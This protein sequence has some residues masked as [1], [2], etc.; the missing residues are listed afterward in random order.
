MRL[1]HLLLTVISLTAIV[2]SAGAQVTTASMSGRITDSDEGSV[3]GAVVIA[4][5][6]ASGT[7]YGATT[8][9]EGRFTMQGMRVGA[10]NV[11]ITYLG[12]ETARI[13]DVVLQLGN[14]YILDA[15]LRESALEL[16]TVTVTGS[17]S[18]FVEEKT[19]P[20]TNINNRQMTLVPSINRSISDIARL[21]PY[22]NGLSFAGGDGRST[23]FTVDG[24]N[25]NNNFGLSSGL[26][27]G[28][29]P[30]SLDAIEE[31]QVVIA[32][33]DVRQ[34]NFIGG[35]INAIT[36]SGTNKFKGSAYV[37]HRDQWLRG[38]HIGDEFLGERDKDIRTVYGATLGGPIVKNRLF[39]FAN[40]EYEK[41][42]QDGLAWRARGDSEAAN[43]AAGISKT[44][45]SDLEAVSNH[46]KEKYGYDTGSWR[47]FP[48]DESNLKYMIRLDWN[49]H[50]NHKLSVRF[51]HTK[52]VA[53]N[54]PNGASN[55]S[56]PRSPKNRIS[57]ASMSFANSMYSMDN[58]VNTVSAEYNARF[59]S[60]FS[61]Q[62]LFTYS[63]IQDVR[64]S[65]SSPFPFIDIMDGDLAGSD[66]NI[67]TSYIAAGYELFTWNNGVKNNVTTITDNFTAYLGRH[68]LTAGVSWEHQFA[69]NNYM[70]EGTGYY[71][72]A[73]LNDFLSDAAPIDFALTYGTNG[74]ERPA[75]AVDFDQFGFYV[76]DDWDITDNFKLTA[77][78]RGDLLSF[79]N[80]I[81]RNNAIYDLDFGGRKIDT[82]V[83]P[84]SRVNWSPRL[85]FTW[86][87][88]KDKSLIVRGGTGLFMGHIPLVFFTNMPT[89]SGLTQQLYT[90][91]SFVNP[92]GEG[93]VYQYNPDLDV[94]EGGMETSI[95]GM[96][97][98]LNIDT[99]VTP[100]DGK[101][102]GKV[103]A[104][105]PNF[106]MPQVWKTSLAVDYSIPVDF[107]FTL[108]AEGMFTKNINAL[109]LENYAQNTANSVNWQKFS[110]A[111]NRL[112][113][114]GQAELYY[115]NYQT[116]TTRRL[117]DASVLTNTNKGYGYTFNFTM[118]M[119]PARNLDI[120]AAY[121]HTE[122]KEVSGMPGSDATSAWTNLNTVNGPNFATVQRSQYVVP[123]Q[124]I[125]SISYTLPDVWWKSSTISLFYRGYSPGGYSF[126]YNGDMNGD[127]AAYDLMY[128]PRDASEIKFVERTLTYTDVDGVDQT[129]TVT[130]KEQSD[131]F[132]AF[133]NQDKYLSKHK[134]EYAEAYAARAPWVHRFD[135]RFL[136]DFNI[137]CGNNV[138]TLQLSLDILN[139]G[140]LINSKWGV[141][142]N[143]ANS[144]SGRIL[145]SAGRDDNNMPTFTMRDLG[146]DREGTVKYPTQTYTRDIHYGQCWS[147]QVGL[148]YMFN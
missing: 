19:G 118:R 137:K 80:N 104:V 98:R 60:R 132:F 100:E 55:D 2:W 37:Y 128:I 33:F 103:A 82:G 57:D 115:E 111:D 72:Y 23:N 91:S 99:T 145:Q 50:R 126:M 117:T 68:T 87:A 35:G 86:D 27:G 36:K 40:F 89:N 64:G 123:D 41:S 84:K 73:S 38:N 15:A 148:R 69:D 109:R 31:V 75:N 24:A 94:F 122:M 7:T 140:N 147:I 43:A 12:A 102:G 21:S 30:I 47:N 120:M 90:M 85:G 107:P 6:E 49:I 53:W 129:K 93:Y 131:A 25:L 66:P 135:V 116:G 141:M 5:H 10:Y 125:G 71:R 56:N 142:K 22:A 96:I 130:A 146:I 13:E 34:T 28:G 143:M 59:G 65:N 14:T 3:I 105:D 61:N 44:T 138:N 139:V 54:P 133:V 32:P 70:R 11:E 52:N 9:P 134:G 62:L 144:H 42:P 67:P 95:R 127:G 51:N 4:T 136:Q 16:D 63:D 97:D 26:P 114:P 112:I 18:R 74:A 81:M 108:T 46:L 78:V 1:K 58:L 119:Q 110:G 8:N 39:F 101:V 76:Q 20:S 88:L 92:D 121:T 79:R 45:V 48:A 29:N 124:V 83:W 77:G 113:Y 17:A 106:K